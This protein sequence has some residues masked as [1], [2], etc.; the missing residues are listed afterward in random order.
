MPILRLLLAAFV[1]VAA[2][3]AG[4]F[5][6]LLVALTALVGLVSLRFSKGR[7]GRPPA[8]T[9]RVARKP[10]DVIDVEAELVNPSSPQI[11]PR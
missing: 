4:V 7:I 2:L 9:R 10:G 11:P 6:A 5:A 1:A 3:V 8:A